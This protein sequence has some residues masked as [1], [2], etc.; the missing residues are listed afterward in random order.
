MPT[1]SSYD[2]I[3]IGAGP[4][5]LAAAI[6]LAEA[7]QRVVVLE[8]NETAGGGVRSLPLT[9]PGF[10]HDFGAAVFPLG[11]GSPFFKRL[12]LERYGLRWIHPDM[13]LAHPLDGG[14]A[15]LLHRSVEATA[16][17]LG[18][19]RAAYRRL[20]EP[21][22]AAWPKLA[23]EI[24]QP[25]VHLPRHL[26][27]LAGFG[28]RAILPI[29]TL[30]DLAFHDE[31]ARALWAGSAA[32]AAL[33]FSAVGG[34]A[35]GLVLGA[36]GHRVGWPIPE[37]GAQA[38]TD[39][40]VA[41]L[42]ALGGEVVTGERVTDLVDLPA[43]R[44]VLAD[45]SPETM[46]MLAGDRLPA[47]YRSALEGWQRGPAAFKL[48]YALDGPIPWANPDC[49]RA[50]TVHLGGTL[51]EIAAS[52]RAAADGRPDPNPYVL[53]AQP[54][55]FDS[56]RAPGGKHTAWAY[57]HVPLGSTMDVTATIEAQIERFA[58][59]FRDRV[60][61]R[62]VLP[63]AALERHDANLVGGDIFG[64]SQ[65]LW[66]V[67]ARPVFRPNPYETGVP[68]L[69]LCSSSTPPGGGVHG[70]CG[71]NAARSALRDVFA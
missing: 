3:V 35:F 68:G 66:Q 14:R 24:L 61:A 30:A 50:A 42:T 16:A 39:A 67:A 22:A 47:R 64:G 63:P 43:T 56:T 60:I 13:P 65:D 18:R 59:G 21:L 25:L 20:F 69:Y 46:L 48:D 1:N 52:E 9:K 10:V 7:G 44:A 45:V 8:A 26:P 2:A 57:S 71:Y 55:L 40:L 4:N 32:H 5:G 41:H 31:P 28:L 36:L 38:I 11:L 19:D 54:S 27:A 17:G 62:N 51:E 12:P 53:L 6:T 58:P 23:E 37:G 29:Q 49:A 33:P 34:S 70:M 15:A